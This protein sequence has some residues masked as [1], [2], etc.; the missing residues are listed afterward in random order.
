M[1]WPARIPW[2]AAGGRGIDRLRAAAEGAVRERMRRGR[3][4]VMPCR[5]VGSAIGRAMERGMP[6]EI[7]LVGAAPGGCAASRRSAS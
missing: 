2:P 6:A 4:E 7:V 5:S 3:I 1:A